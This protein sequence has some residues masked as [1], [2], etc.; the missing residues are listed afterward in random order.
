MR[1]DWGQVRNICNAAWRAAPQVDEPRLPEVRGDWRKGFGGDAGNF[2]EEGEEARVGLVRGEGADCGARN[3]AELFDSGDDFLEARDRSA[4]E[5]FTFENDGEAA[6]EFAFD[7]DGFGV[8][9]RAAEKEVADAVGEACGFC[10]VG[11]GLH[12]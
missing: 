10:G 11:V 2:G 4:R 7:F 12:A 6:V 9:I 8:L 1:A 5:R 3:G